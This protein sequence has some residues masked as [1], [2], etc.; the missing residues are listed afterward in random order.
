MSEGIRAVVA[1]GDE[2]TA[3]VL[4][5]VKG[6]EVV[7]CFGDPLAAARVLPWCEADILILS[8]ENVFRID[9]RAGLAALRVLGAR[10]QMV[11]VD[12]DHGNDFPGRAQHLKRLLEDANLNP[13]YLLPRDTLRLEGDLR[14]L[15]SGP[16]SALP[17]ILAEGEFPFGP[18]SE[19]PK[20]D[21]HEGQGDGHNAGQGDGPDEDPL[22]ALRHPR[23]SVA[24][25]GGDSGIHRGGDGLGGPD[26]V[27]FTPSGN[28]VG[29]DRPAVI[30]QQLIPIFS[31]KGGVGK[32]FVISNL[33]VAVAARSPLR[34]ALLDL[35]FYSNDVGVHLDRLSGPT[36]IDLLPHSHQL[37]TEG[38]GRFMTSHSTGLHLLLGPPRPE[39][40]ELVKTSHLVKVLAQARREF[41]VVFVDTPPDAANDMVY[42]CLEQATRILLITTMDAA[43]VRQM[44]LVLDILS[45]LRVPVAERVMLIANQV[46]EHGP[47][48]LARIS[49]FLG[50]PV[51]AAIP[52]D[53]GIVE[54]SVF[55]GEPLVL[56][57][58]D[59][60]ISRVLLEIASIVYPLETRPQRKEWGRWAR[61]F[62]D[63][64]RR[65]G[66]SSGRW[67]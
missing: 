30:H 26:P 6:L 27:G 1:A 31:P 5:A 38:L 35:D 62:I 39:L 51:S 41:H 12:H 52:R 42:E 58:P 40:S 29:R 36:I 13:G 37:A 18:G 59:H 50:L 56:A 55:D 60:P 2:W 3:S 11:V 61:A 21:N 33:A 25:P 8:A 7:G 9:S 28:G 64:W 34:V 49:S 14:R 24:I 67:T 4:G 65:R 46:H 57:R 53:P 48:S 44:R 23:R 19:G 10:A 20:V 63:R 54:G 17:E 66:S 43:A 15:K 32:T 45:R 47:L 16:G 22:A